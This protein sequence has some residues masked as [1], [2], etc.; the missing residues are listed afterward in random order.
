MLP[1]KGLVGRESE[2]EAPLPYREM[3][4]GWEAVLQLGEELDATLKEFKSRQPGLQKLSRI[5]AWQYC[6]SQ[7]FL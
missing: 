7:F 4:Q 2:A 5:S 1:E 6:E 3:G